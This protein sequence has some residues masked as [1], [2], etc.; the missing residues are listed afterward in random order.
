MLT[1]MTEDLGLIS[2]SAY[3]VRS[4]KSKLRAPLQIFCFSELVLSKKSGD[5]YRAES[6]SIVDGFLPIGED[7][8]RL[9]L[10]NYICDAAH[11]A[12]SDGDR[13]VL[14]LV[15]NTLYAIAYKDAAADTAKAVFELKLMQY[16]G[17]EPI[18]NKCMRCGVKNGLTRF[19]FDGG[20][21]C[22]SCADAADMNISADILSA[23]EFV[24]SAED[25][26]ILSFNASAQVLD[27]LSALAEGYFLN[28]SEK[29]YK[30]LEYLKKIL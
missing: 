21:V 25:R 5:I 8:S 1:V 17:Y 16:S 10:A 18:L 22:S 4:K 29:R 26:K 24:F 2:V 15:L 27:G 19:D 13:R 14:R 9:A 20:V 28:K 11:E 7:L 6:A 12:F 23:L 30:S 3:G